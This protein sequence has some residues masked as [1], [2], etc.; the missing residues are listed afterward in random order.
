MEIEN[1]SVLKARESPTRKQKEERWTQL[2]NQLSQTGDRLGRGIDKGIL[3]TVVAFNALDIHTRQS[4]EGH[5]DHGTGAPWVDIKA[6]TTN[7]QLEQQ[8][9]E[10]FEKASR[11]DTEE[12][13]EEAH[14]LRLQ[15]EASNLAE[16]KKGFKL[17]AEFYQGR[18]T[19]FDARLTLNVFGRG[20]GR[21]ESQGAI[22]QETAQGFEK[23]QK[24]IEYQEEMKAFTQFLKQKYFAD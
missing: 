24:L 10:A 16:T 21:I 17:L 18:Q 2:E 19:S 3:E 4:C 12:A 13:W 1:T 7:P 8:V 15:I 14:R 23:Q 11:E 22:Y 20:I 6:P 5:L 9:D